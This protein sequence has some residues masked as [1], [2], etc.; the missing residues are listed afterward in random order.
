L[1]V[2]T[3]EKRH[4]FHIPVMGTGFTIDTPLRVAKYGISSVI[5]LLDDVL[6]EQMR[7]LHSE[8]EGILYKAIKKTDKDSR[9]RRITAYLN[10]LDKII[11]R[12]INELKKSPFV[13][14]SDITRYFDLLPNGD[15][16][17]EYSRMLHET[18]PEKKKKMQSELRNF[19][20]PGSIDANIMTKCDRD[21]YE[22]GEKLAPQFADAM[23]AFRGFAKSSVSASIVFSAGMNPRL[24]TYVSEFSDFFPDENGCSK[25]KIVLKVSDY[26][27]AIIQGKFLA[28]RGLWVSEFRVESGLNCGGH[29]FSGK[30]HL[31]GVTLSEFYEKREELT[32]LL[33][34]LYSKALVTKG[35][36]KPKASLNF[37]VTAQGGIGTFEENEM[38]LKHYG[39]DGTGWGTPFMLVPEVVNVDDLHLKKLEKAKKK[40]IYLSDS[41]PLNVPFWNLRKSAS[42]KARE[43]RI[44]K[45]I[46]GSRCLKG[47]PAFNQE[48]TTVPICTASRAYQKLKLADLKAKGGSEKQLLKARIEG[49]LQSL[50]CA[51]ISPD[52]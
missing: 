17:N 25:K 29:A 34:D 32:Q 37:A 31:M 19:V 10:L 28:K 16:R 46:P 6:I 36:T 48:F 12:Q 35:L 45:G 30:G 43:I 14:G 2:R 22:R 5:A 20:I 4:T 24:Y 1:A 42:E 40:D 23:S 21:K 27:S 39:L 18:D 47:F 13:D 51:T 3:N 7:K 38:L 44:K 41:S 9:A 15:L 49:I 33:F 11:N 52:R 50:V 26:R 8:R